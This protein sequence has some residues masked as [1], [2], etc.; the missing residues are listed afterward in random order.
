LISSAIAYSMACAD[1]NNDGRIDIV[2]GSSDGY[3]YVLE[4]NFPDWTQKSI[5]LSS[6]IYGVDVSD[7]DNDM[8]YDDIAAVAKGRI[9]Y[10]VMNCTVA[11][12]SIK[13]IFLNGE[14]RSVAIGELNNDSNL[15]IACSDENMTVWVCLGNSTA[16][17]NT[18][19]FYAATEIWSVKT[20]DINGDGLQ[21]IVG[22]GIRGGGG[23][24]RIAKCINKNVSFSVN[25]VDN[26]KGGWFY[27]IALG[28]VDGNSLKDIVGLSWDSNIYYILNNGTTNITI[29]T[30]GA[31]EYYI[32]PLTLGDLDND[33]DLDAI[34]GDR[35]GKIFL[36][37]NI[38][39]TQ[40][41]VVDFTTALSSYLNTCDYSYDN[42]ANPLCTV[43]LIIQSNYA[44]G[45]TVSNLSVV[46]RY[47]AIVPNAAKLLAAYLQAHQ[48]QAI[49]WNITIPLNFSVSS[50]GKVLLEVNV[51]FLL[52]PRLIQQIPNTYYFYEDT[53]AENLICL[54]DYFTD[55]KDDGNLTFEVYWDDIENV[56]VWVN[57]SALSFKTLTLDWYGWISLKVRARD[58]DNLTAESNNFNVEIRPVNDAPR[59]IGGL[60][61][62]TIGKGDVWRE[63]L[64]MYFYD[65]EEKSINLIYTCNYPAIVITGCIATWSPVGDENI[66]LKN[67]I[68]TASDSEWLSGNSAPITLTYR[69]HKGPKYIGGLQSA[70]VVEDTTW[71][72][73][74]SNYFSLGDYGAWFKCSSPY[75]TIIGTTASW[76]PNNDAASIVNLVFTAIDNVDPNLTAESE[77]ITLTFIWV[78]DP[79]E[80]LG[81]LE[82]YTDEVLEGST[83]TL[84]LKLYFRDEEENQRLR[85]ICSSDEIVID[86]VTKIAS[87]TP[88][89]GATNITIKFTAIDALDE[90]LK[91]E[92]PEVKLIFIGRNDPPTAFIIKIAPNRARAGEVIL[93]E[94]YG[95]DDGTVVAY[96]WRSSID[97]FLSSSRTFTLTDLSIGK[98]KIYFKCMDNT[99]KWSEEVQS[100]LVILA[101]EE[102]LLE[103]LK[104][105][106]LLALA[107]VTLGLV[108]IV[109]GKKYKIK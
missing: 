27:S 35:Y 34:T 84:D 21:D 95:T 9:L 17:Y 6:K 36:C 43:P 73:E 30:N 96:E 61:D 5:W 56:S 32:A 64:S 12:P 20:G 23:Y 68:F 13:S 93:F 42:F 60:Q 1:V 52:P 75:I 85:F 18:T 22:G 87:W 53:T 80:Y 39:K 19:S 54:E 92:S 74:L 70:D 108:L 81:G 63:N 77:P 44:G 104:P 45:I 25:T 10:L 49:D 78:N 11:E 76:T 2:C 4:N 79:P 71:S 58:S 86:Q 15:D 99:G 103:I 28:D 102:V 55:E 69:A 40:L 3:V 16:E 8:Q 62:K 91:A 83:W 26:G 50:A 107:L 38:V 101:P 41:E 97:G 57:G 37:R 94:G 90:Q 59:F 88:Q 14:L 67:V 33:G 105:Y 65:P 89:R 109:L 7:L 24:G 46:Y 106:F 31:Y 51:T 72:V 82:N 98:H 47:T 48:A 66:I 29:A 100:E